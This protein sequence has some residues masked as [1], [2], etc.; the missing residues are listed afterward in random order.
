MTQRTD[1]PSTRPGLPWLVIVGLSSLALLWPLTNL[2][3][4]PSGAPRALTLVVIIAACWIGVVAFA[5]IPNPVAVLA[6]VGVGH[7]VITLVVSAI[8]GEPG[9]PLWTYVFALGMDAV[10]GAIAGLIALGVQAALRRTG[11]SR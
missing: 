6:L 2:L 1:S 9:R 11:A 10:W 3:G 4:V 5:R 8:F 7:G